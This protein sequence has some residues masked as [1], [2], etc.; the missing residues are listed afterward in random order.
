LLCQ[1]PELP[2]DYRFMRGCAVVRLDSSA[3]SEEECVCLG[4]SRGDVLVLGDLQSGLAGSG[5]LDPKERCLLAGYHAAPIAALASGASSNGG[6]GG[7]S[8]PWAGLVASGDD[9]GAVRFFDVRVGNPHGAA[10]AGPSLA[11]CA[12]RATAVSADDELTPPTPPGVPCTCLAAAGPAL[13][14]GYANGAIR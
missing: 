13:A 6:K 10:L 14:A 2:D 5:G 11:T 4:T 12:G 9:D 7:G 8:S 1:G 3:S